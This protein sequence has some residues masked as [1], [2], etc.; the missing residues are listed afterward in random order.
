MI[1]RPYYLEK[2]KPFIDIKLVKILTGIRRCG[3][4]TILEMLK[5]ELLSRGVDESHIIARRDSNEDYYET[6][7]SKKM[8]EELKK[9]IVDKNKYYFLLDELQEVNGWEKVIN[10]LLEDYNTDIYVT[11]SNSKLMSSEISTYLTGRYITIPVYT[12]SFKE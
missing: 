9:L 11:G 6:F 8:Y 5:Q 3:K 12:L 1:I 4:S 7:T 10:T 2:I